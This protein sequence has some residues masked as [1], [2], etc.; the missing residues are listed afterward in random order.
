MI[1]TVL[2]VLHSYLIFSR[3]LQKMGKQVES[4]PKA[5]PACSRKQDRIIPNR[6]TWAPCR[7]REV[8]VSHRTIFLQ[9]DSNLLPSVL[10]SSPKDAHIH[11]HTRT[12][13]LVWKL[14]LFCPRVSSLH[15]RMHP[16]GPT[17]LSLP[18][19]CS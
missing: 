7:S 11:R 5:G 13:C 19:V 16:D 6:H 14:S 4:F 12:R 8:V 15:S 18:T 17:T 9:T 3:T 10:F 1:I 2:N